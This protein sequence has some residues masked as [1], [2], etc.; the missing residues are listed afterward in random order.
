[1]R[2]PD[3]SWEFRNSASGLCLDVDGATSTLGQQLDQ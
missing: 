2:Q 3:G 1:M